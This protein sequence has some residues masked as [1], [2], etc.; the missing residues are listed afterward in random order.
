MYEAPIGDGPGVDVRPALP[1]RVLIVSA[2]IGDGHNATGR[3]LQEEVGRLWPGSQV[4]WVDTLDAMGPGVGVAFRRTYLVNVRSTPWLYEFFY[5]SLWRHRWFVGAAKR[6]VGSWAGRRLTRTVEVVDPDVILSTYPVGSAG[7]AWLREHRGLAVP[8]AAWVSDFAPH[9]FWVYPQLDWTFVV[10]PG[11][12]PVAWA[13]APGSRVAVCGPPVQRQFRPGDPIP[14][15]RAFGLATDR[16]VALIACGSYGFGAVQEASEAILALGDAVQTV[17]VCGRNSALAQRLVGVGHPPE[18]LTVLGWVEDMPSLLRAADLVVTNAG[19]ATALEAVA[20]GRPIVMYRPIA[21]HGAANAALLSAVSLAHICRKPAALTALVASMLP[22]STALDADRTEPPEPE[23]GVR[24][25][26]ESPEQSAARGSWPLRASDAFF[27]HVESS[28]VAQQIG[29]VVQVGPVPGRGPLRAADLV[30]LL[31]SRLTVLAGLRRRLSPRGSLRQPGWTMDRHVDAAAHVSKH[32]LAQPA[33]DTEVAAV[34]DRFWSERLPTDRPPWQVLLVTGLTGGRVMVAVK[35]HHA[36]CDG[37]SALGLL[38]RLLLERDPP[39]VR[40]REDVGRGRPDGSARAASA[41]RLIAYRARDLVALTRG[42]WRLVRAGSA[43]P[44]PFNRPMDTPGRR[45]VL[46]ALPH[47]DVVQVARLHRVHTSELILALVAEALHRTLAADGVTPPRLRA[48][49]PVTINRPRRSVTHGNWTGAV[50]LDLPVAA[51]PLAGRVAAIRDALR[52]SLTSG[53]PAA[54]A[55][56]M[57]LIGRLPA[58]VHRWLSRRV[59]TSQFFNVIVSYVPG[60]PRPGTLAGAPV[61]SAY[62]I[63]ALA[64]D[65]PIGVA[66]MRWGLTVGVGLLLDASLAATGD[67]FTEVLGHTLND[68]RAEAAACRTGVGTQQPSPTMSDGR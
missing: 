60:V 26:A 8:V 30:A 28:A 62:P 59:Y 23:L 13:A 38:Q 9:P 44:A 41:R 4:H 55:M 3:A 11:A 24:T 53:E 63:V 15:R 36:L 35:L 42:L 57:H 34:L 27:L 46:A 19:G 1:R 50:A 29:A 10:H 18:R 54:S 5:A 40:Q 45:L 25:L 52:V 17:V 56:V 7:L 37:V 32:R 39:G 47:A 68:A 58:P 43:P 6:C 2:D 14:A 66:A 20:T 22:G 16:F 67:A 31:G 21:A 48:M 64:R 61:L 33:N 12:V 65:V 51:M 49:M